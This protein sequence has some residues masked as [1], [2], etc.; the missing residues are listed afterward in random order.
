MFRLLGS[1]RAFPFA[2]TNVGHAGLKYKFVG[3]NEA[4]ELDGELDGT[5]QQIL[6]TAKTSS[7]GS[8]FRSLATKQ[9]IEAKVLHGLSLLVL[10][11]SGSQVGQGSFCVTTAGSSG[12]ERAKPPH[13]KKTR[14]RRRER[15]KE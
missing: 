5:R 14:R 6:E 10:L 2:T 15:E 4:G 13:T 11:G 7:I 12:N 1:N 3:R 9:V 8:A